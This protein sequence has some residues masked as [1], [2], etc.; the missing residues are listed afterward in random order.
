[1]REAK[2]AEGASLPGVKKK[3]QLFLAEKNSTIH[4]ERRTT[5]KDP[6]Y[7]GQPWNWTTGSSCPEIWAQEGGSK[8]LPR[9]EEAMEN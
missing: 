2:T 7:F 6:E 3:K 5:K 1:L 9:R 4:P 8:F